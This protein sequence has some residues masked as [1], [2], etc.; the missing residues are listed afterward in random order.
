M[1]FIIYI[2]KIGSLFADSVWLVHTQCRPA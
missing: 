2:I 1:S